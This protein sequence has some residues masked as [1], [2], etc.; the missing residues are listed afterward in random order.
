VIP[1]QRV[2]TLSDG[3]PRAFS[4]FSPSDPYNMRSFSEALR[5]LAEKELKS[6]KDIFPRNNRLDQSLR[7]G[8]EDNIF[9]KQKLVL[10]DLTGPKRRFML[11]VSKGHRIPP[12]VWSAGQREFV[13]LLLGLYWLMPAGKVKTRDDIKWVIIEEP[14][15]G[16]HTRAMSSLLFIFLE[17]IKR[18]YKLCI[19]T[20]SSHMLDVMWALNILRANKAKP[21]DV[22]KL[23]GARNSPHLKDIAKSILDHKKKLKAYFFDPSG[24]VK[25]ISALDTQSGDKAVRTWGELIDYADRS[26]DVV[27]DV[28]SR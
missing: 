9:N 17:L 22:L 28:V 20:H 21:D 13:P 7:K 19:S 3:W 8:L 2:L 10:D 5:I 11:E 1:A 24:E 27:R 15:M 16:L 26:G 23:F 14:E 4:H 25:D 12:M 18:G 6:D